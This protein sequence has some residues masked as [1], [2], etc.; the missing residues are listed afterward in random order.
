MYGYV[1][2]V[3]DELKVKEYAA[4]QAVYCGLCHCLRQRCGPVARFVVNYDFTFL[5]MLLDTER[6]TD[7]VQRR[8]PASPHKKKNCLVSGPALELAAELSVILAWW[9]LRD[10]LQDEG[11]GKAVAAGAGMGLL[12]RAY[13][14]AAA[15]QPAFA[16]AC[17]HHMAELAELEW[18]GCA[19][20]DRAADCFAS[21]SASVAAA[22]PEEAR[23]RS[24]R[25]LLYHMG[26]VV[27]LLDAVDDLEKDMAAGRY[28]PLVARFSLEGAALPQ[29]AR[30]QLRLTLRHSLNAMSA[31]YAL[32]PPNAFQVLTENIVYLGIPAAVA[33]LLPEDGAAETE[34]SNSG[35][36]RQYERSL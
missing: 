6:Q 16:E 24:L 27:Y 19:S 4:Y 21:L 11:V 1:R 23:R 20:L 32:L 26:R 30:E 28:N 3:K 34:S 10:N 22:V 17:A 33:R 5:A 31:A 35:L 36:E 2:P 14:K 12:R 15:R 7:Y 25:E 18:T 8:C 29:A 13:G 9:K